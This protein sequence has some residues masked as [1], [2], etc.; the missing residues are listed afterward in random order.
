MTG[1]SRVW[2]PVADGD[3][4]TRLTRS[5]LIV[6]ALYGLDI[7]EKYN[8]FIQVHN[9]QIMFVTSKVGVFVYHDYFDGSE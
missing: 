8:N 9:A 4:C 3:V 7:D 1:L 5:R 6:G 2:L